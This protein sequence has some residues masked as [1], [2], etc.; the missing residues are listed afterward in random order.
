MVNFTEKNETVKQYK[1]HFAGGVRSR[2]AVL[3]ATCIPAGGLAGQVFVGA[4][5]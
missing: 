5:S 1:Q 4:F 2:T 3:F